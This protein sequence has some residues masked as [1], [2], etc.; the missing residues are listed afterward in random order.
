M[1]LPAGTQGRHAPPRATASSCILD[2]RAQQA[3]FSNA[4]AA[5]AA[6]SGPAAPRLLVGLAADAGGLPL[7]ERDGGVDALDVVVC[8]LHRRDL[9]AVHASL[10]QRGNALERDKR[11][12]RDCHGGQQRVHPCWRTLQR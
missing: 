1:V 10:Q 2:Q 5:A 4:T 8:S 11:W 6:A 12:D 7:H 9:A 3:P